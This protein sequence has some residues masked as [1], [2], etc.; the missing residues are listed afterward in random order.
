MGA[1][2]CSDNVTVP[3]GK[4]GT[5]FG[6]NPLCC[7]AANATIDFLL[8]NNLSE[9]AEAKG[10]YLAGK[11]REHGLN[12]VR[13]VRQFGLMIGIEVRE[14]VVPLVLKMLDA[15]VLVFP[16]GATVLRVYPPLTVEY[17]LLDVIADKLISVLKE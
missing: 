12:K 2:L 13:E 17:D 11:L 15:G 5:T 1:V 10:S 14:K 3:V 4:H 8:E 7:A 9:Q 16:A 6:G